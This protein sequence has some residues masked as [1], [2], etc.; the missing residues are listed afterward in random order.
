VEG[1]GI[2]GESDE[3]GFIFD[4]EDDG[5]ISD[6]EIAGDGNSSSLFLPKR[7]YLKIV[8]RGKGSVKSGKAHT[9]DHYENE[10]EDMHCL[11]STDN[12]RCLKRAG[13]LIKREIESATSA[14][15][16][17]FIYSL[18]LLLTFIIIK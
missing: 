14:E 17:L 7:P 8:V 18:L 1:S 3:E 2:D 5:Y 4:E 11:I 10:D 16:Y 6:T 9:Q 15:V 12:E 13:F